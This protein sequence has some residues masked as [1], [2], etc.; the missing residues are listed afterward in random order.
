MIKTKKHSSAASPQANGSASH[1]FTLEKRVEK[2]ED[3]K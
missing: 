2:R 3:E 1:N